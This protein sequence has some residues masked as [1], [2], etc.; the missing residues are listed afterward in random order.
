MR[1]ANEQRRGG[2]LV[3]A[4]PFSLT[5]PRQALERDRQIAK[6][7]LQRAQERGDT[8]SQHYAAQSLQKATTALL[9]AETAKPRPWWRR[10]LHG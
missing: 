4:R 9:I 8:R 7:R 10:V 6:A 1:S 2:L 5:S 3:G